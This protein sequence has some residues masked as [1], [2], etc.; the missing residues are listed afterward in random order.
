MRVTLIIPILVATVIGSVAALA[1]DDPTF[2]LSL[3]EHQFTPS[4]LTVPADKRLKLTIK[5]LDTLPAEFESHDFKAEKIVPAGGEVSV[6]IG[7][8]KAGTYGFFDD[9]H[10][11]TKGS[12]IAK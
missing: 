1:A 5:N 2:E 12:L 7:P 8:L 11:Q 3:K 10:G 6:Y 9:F 4:E